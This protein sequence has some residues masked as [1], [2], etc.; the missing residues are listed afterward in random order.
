[1]NLE[2]QKN[3]V[4]KATS[5]AD[6]LIHNIFNIYTEPCDDLEVVRKNLNSQADLSF[7]RNLKFEHQMYCIAANKISLMISEQ[8]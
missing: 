4:R 7:A 1:M 8:R 6:A 3:Q 2:E 5:V